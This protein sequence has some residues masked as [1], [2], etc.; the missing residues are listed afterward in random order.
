MLDDNL[1]RLICLVHLDDI[2][3]RKVYTSS[4]VLDCHEKM[5]IWPSLDMAQ[6]RDAYADLLQFVSVA[7]KD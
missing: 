3:Y 5:H 2:G 4:D 1:R 7:Q 6:R